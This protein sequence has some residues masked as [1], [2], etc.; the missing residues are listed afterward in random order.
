MDGTRDSGLFECGPKVSP[1]GGRRGRALAG[2][3]TALIGILPFAEDTDSL[4]GARAAPR[5]VSRTFRLGLVAGVR[6][7]AACGHTGG[8]GGTG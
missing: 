5:A 8:G 6:Q 3:A 4:P 1:A 7:G 2:M